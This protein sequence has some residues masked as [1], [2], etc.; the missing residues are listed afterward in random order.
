M[1]ELKNYPTVKSGDID[2]VGYILREITKIRP[3]DQAQFDNIKSRY[4][5][6][7]KVS[8]SPSGSL[9]VVNT[10]KVGDFAVDTSFIYILIDNAGTPEWRRSSLASW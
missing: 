5:A 10:D 6:G 9:D 7:R 3:S 2:D 8:R 1:S 4:I